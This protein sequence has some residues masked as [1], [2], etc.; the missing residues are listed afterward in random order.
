MSDSTS[1]KLYF[2]VGLLA[3]LVLVPLVALAVTT[4]PEMSDR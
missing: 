1:T 3:A 4:P 2:I